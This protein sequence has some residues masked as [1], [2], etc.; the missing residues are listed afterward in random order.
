[1]PNK[2]IL[3]VDDEKELLSILKEALKDLKAQIDCYDNAGFAEA[4]LDKESFD[5]IL[6]DIRMPYVNGVQFL[7]SVRNSKLNRR[8]PVFV[9]SG[10]LDKDT[11][12]RANALGVKGF[13]VKPIEMDSLVKKVGDALDAASVG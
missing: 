10:H 13:F 5:V 4:K 2:R 6:T 3:I 7:K 1:M 11:I 8:T 12:A 9:V